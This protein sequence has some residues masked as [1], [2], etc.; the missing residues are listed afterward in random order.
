MIAGV[1]FKVCGLTSLVDAEAAD[2]VGADYLGFILHPKSPRYVSLAQF[3]AMAARLPPRKKVAV[4]VEPSL[5]ALAAIKA[6]GFDHVQLHFA[7]ETPFSMASLWLDVI[8]PE[9]LWLAPRVP[10]GKDFDLAFVPLADT[11]L[12]D[13]YHPNFFGGSGHTGDWKTFAWHRTQ[14]KKVNWV[15]AGGLNA[16]NI[17]DAIA[18]TGARFVDVNS[19]VEAAPG[20][21]DPEKLKVFAA[22]LARSVRP[23]AGSAPL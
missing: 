7:N 10:P 23:S 12:L 20:R 8:P 16:E 11:I 21:K 13:T 4:V 18:A 1:R 19:G 3:E 17:G 6:A 15:L 22:A 14:F 5:E 9:M 2:A